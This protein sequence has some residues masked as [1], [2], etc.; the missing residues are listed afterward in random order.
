MF[1]ILFKV[2]P[3][4]IYT[5][6]ALA[7]L[8]F[9]V[10]VGLSVHRA[11]R[12]G[13]DPE[14]VKDLCFYLVV[15]AI[16]GSR[17]FFVILAWD[18]FRY[19]PFE[20]VRFW[21]GGLVFYGG[22]LLD[23]AVAAA[24][25]KY[26]KLPVLATA[27]VL[28]PGLALGQAI[29]RIGCLAAGCCYGRPGHPPW[30]VVFTDPHSLAPLHIPLHP[31]QAYSALSLLGIFLVLLIID[32]RAKRAGLVFWT[33]GLLHGLA[34]AGLEFWRGDFRGSWL[35]TGLSATQAVSFGLAAVS[36]IVLIFLLARKPRGGTAAEGDGA[37]S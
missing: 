25:M 6:G 26:R 9:L 27:D 35:D 13:L 37:P 7:A 3:L 32:R 28:A 1:P 34:R 29:G 23:L 4:T 8:G 16:V 33:Y 36:F 10:G 14:A 30:A 5:Y 15:A 20:I 18:H 12:A 24:Y 21:E 11:R 19:H 17:L 2:G 22:L 31:T